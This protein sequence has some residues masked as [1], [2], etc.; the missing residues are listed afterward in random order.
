MDLPDP[1]RPRGTRSFPP[2]YLAPRAEFT[3]AFVALWAV[4]GIL[5]L[6]VVAMLILR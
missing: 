2:Q 1:R 3:Q 4:A 5:L 6:V